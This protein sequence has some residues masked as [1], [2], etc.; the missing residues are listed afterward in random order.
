MSL[1][2]RHDIAENYRVGVKQQSRTRSLYEYMKVQNVHIATIDNKIYGNI[3]TKHYSDL[4][5]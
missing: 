3:I 4:I 2:I 1:K 5:L